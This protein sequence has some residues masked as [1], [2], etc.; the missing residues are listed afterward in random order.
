M[1]G[2][3]GSLKTLEQR[4]LATLSQIQDPDLNKDIVSVGFVKDLILKEKALG[5]V[6]ISLT[7]E[8]TTP[9]CPVKDFFKSEAERL[10]RALPG[11]ASVLVKLTAQVRNQGGLGKQIPGVRNII[12][13]GAGKGGVG[14]S[15]VAASLALALK[16]L[17]SKVGLLDADIYG[18]SMGLIMNLSGMPEVKNGRIQPK[19]S[20]GIPVMTF[21]YFAPVGD[22]VIWRGAMSGKAV[23]QMLFDVDWGD[24]D[25][26]IVDLPPGTGDIPISLIHSVGLVGS[27]V[28]STP[29]KISTL[30][31]EKAIALFQKMNV[32]VLGVV[33]NMSGSVCPHCKKSISTE[34]Q[35]NF[36]EKICEEKRVPFLGKIPTDS[37]IAQGID[38]GK[39]TLL[40][41]SLKEINEVYLGLAQKVAQQVSIVQHRAQSQGEK[42]TP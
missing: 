11:V 9:A 29:H 39:P 20:A 38:Q 13:V 19:I 41:A 17:G 25:Y 30:D 14:K 23:E 1:E 3:S 34:P 40:D 6:D 35:L 15:T 2:L 32:P 26:L 42:V 24:L 37:R 18:P 8:L 5:G 7:L 22:A 4:V 28:V 12:A 21:A 16:Q 27:L 33:E 10:L 36:V 31:T